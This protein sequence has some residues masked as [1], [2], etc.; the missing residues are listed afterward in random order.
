MMTFENKTCLC[1]DTHPCPFSLPETETMKILLIRPQQPIVISGKE[2]M[3]VE[4]HFDVQLA[5]AQ[6]A[7]RALGQDKQ[8]QV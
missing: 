2:A 1:V 4:I 3:K 5:I 7:T 8:V 6:A